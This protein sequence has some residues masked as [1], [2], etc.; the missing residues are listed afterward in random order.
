MLCTKA[1]F[2]PVE[3]DIVEL[4]KDVCDSQIFL[5]FQGGKENI[6]SVQH[7]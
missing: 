1:E 6:Y 5:S 2:H 3:R 4:C 7:R